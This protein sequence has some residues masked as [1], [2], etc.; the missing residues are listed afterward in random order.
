MYIVTSRLIISWLAKE[1]K[2]KP[3]LLLIL[4]L[5]KDI[6]TLRPEN[7]FKSREANPLLEP[8]GTPVSPHIRDLSNADGMISNLWGIWCCISWR[9]S[10]HGK[11]FKYQVKYKNTPK[12]AVWKYKRIYRWCVCKLAKGH[13]IYRFTL[14]VIAKYMDAVKKI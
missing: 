1:T 4:D 3:Y 5:P 6:K 13:V 8:Q 10:S 14:V 9:V 7:I 12:L 11:E 2:S